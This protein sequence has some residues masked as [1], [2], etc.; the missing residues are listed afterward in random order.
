M[1]VIEQ[2]KRFLNG[3]SFPVQIVIRNT[4]LDLSNYLQYVNLNASNIDNMI[5]QKQA[6]N[7]ISFLEE[8]D[9]RQGLIYVKEFYLIVPFYE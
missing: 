3:L 5:L 4:Y 9:S 8:I 7:Y 2:Y 1:I 6:Q